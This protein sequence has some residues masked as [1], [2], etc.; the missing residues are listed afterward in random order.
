[1]RLNELALCGG[2]RNFLPYKSTKVQYSTNSGL[3]LDNVL[4]KLM[5][6]VAS[7]HISFKIR[8]A[9]S[10]TPLCITVLCIG[11]NM[12]GPGSVGGIA[13]P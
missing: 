11:T 1:M 2:S 12:V 10:I 7:D 13:T 3:P 4:L 5:Q 6:S 9:R 8:F